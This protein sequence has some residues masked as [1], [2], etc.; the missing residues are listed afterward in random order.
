MVEPPVT[1]RGEVVDVLHGERVADPYRW[2]E[3]T[4]SEET[5]SWITAE[6]AAT[7][8]FMARL[9]A[10]A[11]IRSRLTEL[12]DVTRWSAPREHSGRWFATRH[13]AGMNQPVLYVADSPES[14][15][16]V[17]L[18]PNQLAGD[19]TVALG[20]WSVSPD[21]RLVAYGTS[22]A[23][24]DW[25]TWRVRDVDTAIDLDDVVEWS[26]WGLAAWLPDSSGF[27][28]GALDPPPSGQELLAT[29][30]GLRLQL[31]VLGSV[32][33]ADP[34]FYSPPTEKW[35]PWARTLEHGHWL[36][37]TSNLGTSTDT[38]VEIVDLTDPQRAIQP[39]IPAPEANSEVVG[40]DGATFYVVTNAGAPNKRVV[41]I[42]LARPEPEHWREVIPEGPDTIE[43]VRQVG[44]VLV[45]SVL[46]DASSQ[47][48]IWS[49]TGERLRNV[50]LPDFVSVIELSGTPD[51][52]TFFVGLTSFTD[53]AS[54]W[55]GDVTN[56]K[57]R[58][59]HSS[60]P[61]FDAT[62]VVV[63]RVTATSPDGTEVP[64]FVM[65]RRDV[66][67][68]GDVPALL[69]GYGGFDIAITPTFNASRLVWVE[70][71]GVL[72]VA[73]LRGG[74]EFGQA[75]YDAGRLANKQNVFDDFAACARWLADS[76]WSRPERIAANGGSN[77]GL[78]VGA[79]LTQH[80]ELISAAVPEVG[81]LDMLRYHLFTI[82]WSWM[83]DYGDPDDP[84][85]YQWV[86]ACSPLHNLSE[87]TAYP[88]TL[89]MTGDH[90]DRVV[91]GHSF[92]FAAALQAIQAGD[93][94][95]L[96][97]VET[98]GGHGAGTPVAKQI[99]ARADMLAFCEHVLGV[100][101]S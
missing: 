54:V 46:Q 61:P 34:V 5:R 13:D 85:Q 55:A 67:P 40:N 18:D 81:V 86:R 92:K 74:G 24:S 29:N 20:S 21:G 73:N 57:L 37:I 90:D 47:L 60:A 33:A 99:E 25:V 89:V 38:T 68:A 26:K 1:R 71:G 98:S 9:P 76:G 87:G 14:A 6:N 7:D 56:G 64:M 84:E 48:Q 2:L 83:S 97:R 72:A 22:E 12:W 41:A 78:L 80:P 62:S 53:P 59:L 75:W 101:S 43:N 10:R 15:G 4:E 77:G 8:D 39:L 27:F 51:A 49:T 11:S 45:A 65:H 100:G 50:E 16:Q 79:L 36:V 35:S 28:Y 70:R 30:A 3:D 52:P 63:D 17:L 95:I 32:A 23:G 93:R 44:G 96:I 88:A 66:S 42:E 91:P 19:G 69:Y 31:H 94:P 82:G 58:Q